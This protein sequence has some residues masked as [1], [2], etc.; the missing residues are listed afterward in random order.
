MR[1]YVTGSRGFVGQTLQQQVKQDPQWHHFDIVTDPDIDIRDGNALNASLR[2]F[3][4]NAVLHLAAQSNVPAA[5]ANPVET[6]QINVIGTLNL[7]DAIERQIPQARLLFV[8]S[9]DGYG[10]VQE[11]Q[12]PLK[13]EQPLLPRN[14]YAASK[15]AAE[16]FVLERVRRG[17]INACCTR[18][19]NHTGPGQSVR[20]VIPAIARQLALI[21]R[22]AQPP[23]LLTGDLDIT[24]DFLDVRDVVR[25]YLHLLV[26]ENAIENVY[27]I[28]SGVETHLQAAASRMAEIAGLTVVFERDP[29]LLRPA[30]QRRVCGDATRLR[31]LGWQPRIPFDT[32]LQEIVNDWMQ[33]V[34]QERA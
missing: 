28:C 13:E 15:V 7:L 1:L 20:F 30:E 22:S 5:I 33:Q 8:G 4:P 14:P 9:S 21:H 6:A 11:N 19:F 31:Q 34:Q 25:A 3:H 23:R 2:H 29:A 27:N 32:T 16:Q 10:L 24:R 26:Q 12:L 17:R 18:S